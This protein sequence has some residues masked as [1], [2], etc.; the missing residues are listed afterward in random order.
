MCV[1]VCVCPLIE[2]PSKWQT[3]CVYYTVTLLLCQL[4]CLVARE[5]RCCS[6]V[7]DR[8]VFLEMRK[9]RLRKRN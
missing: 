5:Q 1:S 9:L 7:R 3:V 2:C 4:R 8:M 6:Q